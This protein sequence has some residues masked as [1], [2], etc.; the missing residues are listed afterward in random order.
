MPPCTWMLRLAHRSAAGSA[1][2]G[3]HRGGE[4]ELVAAGGG[5]AG[6]VPHGGGRQLG[7]H[8][9]V[10]AVV[11]DRLEHGDRAAELLAHLGVLGGLLG[12]LAGDA[13]RLG[14]E[15]RAGEVDQQSDGRRGGRRPARRRSVDPAGTA[16]RVEVRRGPRSSRRQRRRSTTA[17]SSPTGTRRTSARP[18]PSTTP[19]EPWS[20]PSAHGD[21]HHRFPRPRRSRTVGEA[22]QPG[23]L[24][25]RRC[26][27]RRAPRWRSPSART[28]P[29]VRPDRA[30]RPRRRVPRAR[31]PTRRTPRARAG[32]ASRARPRRPRSRGSSR[33]R[34][35]AAPGQRHA[36]SCLTR[37]SDDRVGKGAVV[38]GDGD[39][40]GGKVSIA[41]SG[42]RVGMVD[43]SL[44]GHRVIQNAVWAK[45]SAR[46]TPWE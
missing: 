26:R 36:S 19:A 9:H 39:R 17:T 40:H 22:G 41:P 30:P 16:G 15:D 29:G 45:S 18:P 8:E 11:L 4:R 27:R 1:E 24:R 13:G 10:G 43:G 7:G 6:R 33:R 32:R 21:R 37:K 2:R 31:S 28:A 12:A 3:G 23:G 5:G 20:N 38:I 44:G 42:N 25:A 14:G 34:L 35:R 46:G